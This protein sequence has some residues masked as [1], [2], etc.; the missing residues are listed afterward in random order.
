MTEVCPIGSCVEAVPC[1]KHEP[2]S[3]V[4][5]GGSSG[6][7]AAVRREVFRRDGWTCVVCGLVD[8]SGRELEADH[9]VPVAFGGRNVVE[10]GQTLCC[11]CHRRK[12]SREAASARHRVK[13]VRT[14]ERHP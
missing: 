4:K 10:N 3:W 12:S 6:F 8:R 11:S 13:A 2:R 1:P 7:P 14:P 9:V 5:S